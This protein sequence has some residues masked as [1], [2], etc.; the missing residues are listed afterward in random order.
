[1]LHICHKHSC[2]LIDIEI[3]KSK[4][5]YSFACVA[6]E[7]CKYSQH[8][9]VCPSPVEYPTSDMNFLQHSHD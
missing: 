2:R 5:V 3:H 1:M 8:R 7:L 4:K 9:D 6:Q